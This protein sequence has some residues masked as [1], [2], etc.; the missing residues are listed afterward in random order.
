M[1]R[2]IPHAGARGGARAREPPH[3]AEGGT[4]RVRDRRRLVPAAQGRPPGGVLSLASLPTRRARDVPVA[5]AAQMAEADR[6]ASDGL[7][8]PLDTLMAN[9]SRQVMT[10]TRHFFGDV[11]GMDVIA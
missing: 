5:T 8:V 7:G 9:A 10:A 2:P 11:G 3:G 4:R 1:A 6:I